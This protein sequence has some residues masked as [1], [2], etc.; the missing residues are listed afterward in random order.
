MKHWPFY[1]LKELR[2]KYQ[3]WTKNL[4]TVN[5]KRLPALVQDATIWSGLF[6]ASKRIFGAENDWKNRTLSLSKNFDV[7]IKKKYIIQNSTNN[8][9]KFSHRY[10]LDGGG[11]SSY[12]STDDE[13]DDSTN[14]T[15]RS[16]T[17]SLPPQPKNGSS[18]YDTEDELERF[19]LF[20]CVLFLAAYV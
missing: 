14:Q 6:T 7:L 10:R 5:G 9:F 19:W 3:T 13:D 20:L 4:T 11:D 1:K 12:E 16:S 8:T 15:A 2:M 18:D 17:N